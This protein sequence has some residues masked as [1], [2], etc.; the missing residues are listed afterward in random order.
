ML[1]AGDGDV[2]RTCGGP[3]LFKVTLS[4]S[5]IFLK[6]AELYRPELIT[7]LRELYAAG[8]KNHQVEYLDETYY[9]SLTSLFEDP[10]KTEFRNRCH[11]IGR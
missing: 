9:H 3:S 8:E 1:P 2:H 4:M 7:L 6:Q 10:D 5:G 11:C